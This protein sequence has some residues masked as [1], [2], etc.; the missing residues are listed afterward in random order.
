MN[1]KEME[2][3]CNEATKGYWHVTYDNEAHHYRVDPNITTAICMFDENGDPVGIPALNLNDAKFI[4]ASRT[5]VPWAIEELKAKDRRIE[6]LIAV[7]KA[8]RN[9][10]I[11]MKFSPLLNIKPSLDK[12]DETLKNLEKE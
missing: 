1:L 3:L 6:K 5:W 8:A 2:K 9:L 11:D 7:V 4:A 10:S 12:L